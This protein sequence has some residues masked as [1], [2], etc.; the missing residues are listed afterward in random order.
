MEVYNKN[1]DNNRNMRD[2]I[3]EQNAKLKDATL[4]EKL[5]YFKE[6]YLKMTLVVIAIAIFI[7]SVAYTMI[8]APDETAFA[9]YF[10]NDSGYSSDTSLQ[11]S[12]TEHLGI[13]TREYEV[14]IDAT[15]TY[16]E[17][18]SYE[19]YASIQRCMANIAGKTLDVIVGDKATYEHFSTSEI[20][21]DLTTI[22]PEDLLEKFKDKLVYSTLEET[23][24]SI[25][26]AIIVTDAPKLMEY[27][28][29]DH[30]D[31]Y[32]SVIA[33]SQNIDNVI[34]FLRFIYE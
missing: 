24:E 19:D 8:T 34:A 7:C 4:R 17:A 9:A 21:L 30:T 3:R 25:P 14:Y 6:Y 12:F 20:F 2:E 15:A 33:N 28:Y 13:D 10:F 29:Y 11:D 27:H 5:A 18:G 1:R 26:S 32:F 22:L 16:S 23:G 31:A